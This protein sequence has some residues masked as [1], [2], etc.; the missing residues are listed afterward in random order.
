M[1]KV[2]ILFLISANIGVISYGIFTLM[3]PGLIEPGF[4]YLAKTNLAFLRAQ[5]DQALEYFLLS[6]RLLGAFNFSLAILNILNLLYGYSK[7]NKTVMLIGVI[8]SVLA[9]LPSMVFDWH[10][11]Y[12]GLM[13]ILEYIFGVGI[14]FFSL[15]ILL[16]PNKYNKKKNK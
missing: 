9:Y 10:V 16:S 15:I 3:N 2:A 5:N 1:Y 4:A 13:E 7:N 11:G 6:I 8:G 14:L 12:F